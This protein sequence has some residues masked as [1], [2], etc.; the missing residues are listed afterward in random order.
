MREKHMKTFMIEK[1]RESG[2]ITVIALMI[3]VVLTLIGIMASRTSTTDVQ[4]AGNEIPHKQSFFVGE[5]GLNRE[6]S[7]VGRGNYAVTQVNITGQLADQTGQTNGSALPAPTPHAV[8]GT[9]YNFTLDYLGYFL[10]P[11]GYSVIH[12]SRYDYDIDVVGGRVNVAS[13]YYKIGPRAE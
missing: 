8:A 4:I 13:R 3:L 12:F 2:S 11:P 9:A 1:Q 10:P 6:A 5:G 7:E